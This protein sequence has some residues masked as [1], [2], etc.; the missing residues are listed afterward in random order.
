MEIG[1]CYAP[2]W[3]TI[4]NNEVQNIL[5]FHENNKNH[6]KSVWTNEAEKKSNLN[7]ESSKRK[8]LENYLLKQI[9]V[10]IQDE[11]KYILIIDNI[12]F[13]FVDD[14]LK[15]LNSILTNNSWIGFSII[16]SWN[17][18]NNQTLLHKLNIKQISLSKVNEEDFH[19]IF[20]TIIDNQFTSNFQKAEDN[21]KNELETKLYQLIGDKPGD[22]QLTL[23]A[24]DVMSVKDLVLKLE[25]IGINSYSRE[26]FFYAF[27]IN[28]LG[29]FAQIVLFVYLDLFG[30]E[31][32]P[33]NTEGFSLILEKI[34]KNRMILNDLLSLEAI[35]KAIKQIESHHL[36]YESTSGEYSIKN[37]TLK[38]LLFNFESDDYLNKLK[39]ISVS[40]KRRGYAAII[41]GWDE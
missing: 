32:K 28:Q 41:Y 3:I 24:L 17:K 13:D 12:E 6:S 5:T 10:D 40:V 38:F 20:K 1:F 22:I 33:C 11:K 2:V 9:K 29:L 35:E 21:D 36:I 14:I 34:R 39:R 8:N 25:E 31:N 16:T 4:N 26:A 15:V 23:S 19:G 18:S 7:G 27:N 37:D 30:C